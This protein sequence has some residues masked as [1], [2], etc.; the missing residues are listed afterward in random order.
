MASAAVSSDFTSRDDAK[1][2]RQ[3]QEQRQSGKMEAEIDEATGKMINPHNP[4]FIVQAPWYLNQNAPSLKHHNAWNAKKDGTKEWYKRGTKGD[5]K[6]KFIKGACTNCGATTHSKKE[7]MERPRQKGARWTGHDLAPD[8]FIQELDLDY[9]GKRDR[10]NGYLPDDYDKVVERFHMVDEARRKEKEA[11]LEEKKKIRNGQLKERK[12]R[13][14]KKKKT[15]QPK[16][17]EDGAQDSDAVDSDVDSDSDTDSDTDTDTDAEGDVEDLGERIKDF[18]KQGVVDTRDNRVRTTTRNLRIREDTARYLLNLDV[19]SAYYDPKARSMRDNPMKHVP[20]KEQGVYRGDNANRGMGDSAEMKK[21]EIF[22]WDAYKNGAKVHDQAMPTQAAM[23]YN[24]V[25]GRKE[26]LVQSRKDELKQKYNAIE[27]ATLPQDLMFAQS[28]VYV[29]YNMDGSL[30]RGRERALIRSKY[31]ED[32]LQ[33][34]HTSIFGS[35]YCTSSHKWG[36]RCCKQTLKN[37][38]C[39]GT[40][41]APTKSLSSSAQ[42]VSERL[43]RALPPVPSFEPPPQESPPVESPPSLL[44]AITTTTTEELPEPPRQ[45]FGHELENVELDEEKLRKAK[46]D[47]KKRMREEA[48][49]AEEEDDRKRKYNSGQDD[50]QL[51]AE[52][53]EAYRLL[54]TRKNDPMAS[55]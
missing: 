15:K 29:E 45:T 49:A 8:E 37:A 48:A 10:W 47:M 51:T 52:E 44:N 14:R 43:E 23:M 31:E 24:K 25:N 36:Y 42:P 2:A 53:Y 9:D 16:K 4:Q 13:R 6:T 21:L 5:V 40:K 11:E 27:Q 1:D 35:W 38:Y 33:G 3:K 28:D 41:D 20:E 17:T 39:L 30:A 55:M 22:C 18:E 7:C 12:Q 34:N 46:K 54:R 26:D 32:T 19:N 50:T